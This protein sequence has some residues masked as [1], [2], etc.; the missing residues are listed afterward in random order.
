MGQLL[1]RVGFCLAVCGWY[2]ACAG[3]PVE[4]ETLHP[5]YIQ[6]APRTIAVLPMDNMSVDLDATPLVRPIV[7]ERLA[8]KGYKVISLDKVDDILKNQGVLISHDVYG[9]NPA[10]LGELLGAD[11]VLYGTIT[12]FSTKYAV[13]YAS[14]TVGLKLEMVDCRTGELLWQSEHYAS[15]N[16]VAES[17]LILLSEED[18]EKAIGKAAAYN[19]AFA[20]LESYRPYA[21]QA[22][23]ECMAGLPHGYLGASNYPWD[24]NPDQLMDDSIKS[25]LNSEPVIRTFT[26]PSRFYIYEDEEIA[27]KK[28]KD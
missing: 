22:V 2:T 15:E 28:K 17:L 16:T 14:V 26:N 9:F 23:R 21:E 1:R 25:L 19:A 24:V 10:R 3:R 8:Y 12:E 6:L 18:I 27:E 11:A 20:I 13:L 7:H 5:D 4:F